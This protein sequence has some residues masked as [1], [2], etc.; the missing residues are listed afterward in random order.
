MYSNFCRP[1]PDQLA[2]GKTYQPIAWERYGTLIS[3]YTTGFGPVWTEFVAVSDGKHGIPFEAALKSRSFQ[4]YTRPMEKYNTKA[5]IASVADSWTNFVLTW[6]FRKEK[7]RSTPLVSRLAASSLAAKASAVYYFP[8]DQWCA[9]EVRRKLAKDP[10]VL[11]A[12]YVE[13]RIYYD[14]SIIMV[15]VYK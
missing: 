10:R 5:F 8:M 15:T 11:Y 14:L 4:L 1:T 7:T 6:S 3:L 9:S 12:E 2:G 13:Q